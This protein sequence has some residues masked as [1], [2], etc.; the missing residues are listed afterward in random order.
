MR[1]DNILQAMGQN[2]DEGVHEV[3]VSSMV[4][5]IN[6]VKTKEKLSDYY[7][8]KSNGPVNSRRFPDIYTV[9]NRATGEVRA[10]EKMRKKRVS[11]QVFWTEVNEYRLLLHPSV[12]HLYETLEDRDHWYCVTDRMDLPN[13]YQ[14]IPKIFPNPN[15]FDEI[16]GA[17][18]TRAILETIHFCHSN[19]VVHSDLSHEHLLLDPKPKTLGNLVIVGFGYNRDYR[20]NWSRQQPI[21]K[22]DG[23]EDSADS[24]KNRKGALVAPSDLFAAPET[25]LGDLSQFEKPSDIWSVGIICYQLLT[26]GHPYEEPG[27]RPVRFK[28]NA[29]KE[30]HFANKPF[31]KKLSPLA[32][33]FLKYLLVYNFEQRPTAAQALEHEWLRKADGVSQTVDTG[34]LRN[35]LDNMAN[36]NATNKL[37]IAA[38]IHIVSNLLSPKERES[39]HPVFRYI[40]Q[41]RDNSI[42]RDE[43]RL[44]FA[45][46]HGMDAHVTT[47]EMLE[48]SFDKLDVKKNG[49]I[50]YSEFLAA[51]ADDSIVLTPE[52]LR[53]TFRSFDRSKT[54]KITVDDAKGV[55]NEG[56]KKKVLHKRDAIELFQGFDADSDGKISFE[57][58]YFRRPTFIKIVSALMA[59]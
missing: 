59:L 46:T 51:A 9:K 4:S 29:W 57:V 47:E 50:D 5:H 40:D 35:A 37:E 24:Q 45:S 15:E 36:F 33:D 7:E 3:V 38:R 20:N 43:L 42:T 56:R 18:I 32:K 52:N 53:A 1:F 58:S 11:A 19:G 30:D 28:D 54:G 2:S 6:L 39:L 16:Q 49:V 17:V 55:F 8:Y 44:A 27:V 14:A 23:H 41:N 22:D 48:S 10:L 12:I 21:N 34:D 26:K 31:L 25:R 13:L